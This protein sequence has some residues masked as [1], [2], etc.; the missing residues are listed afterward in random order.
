MG[1][2]SPPQSCKYVSFHSL[3]LVVENNKRAIQTN[4]IL[5]EHSEL[6]QIKKLLKSGANNVKKNNVIS[7]VPQQ[8][9]KSPCKKTREIIFFVKLHF[10]QF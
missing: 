5:K 7:N 10:W 2:P 8:I 6:D 3:L 9:K 4:N 1:Y